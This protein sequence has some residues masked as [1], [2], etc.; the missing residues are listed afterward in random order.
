MFYRVWGF[1]KGVILYEI[2]LKISEVN[3]KVMSNIKVYFGKI[4]FI[5]FN[6]YFLF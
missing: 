5:I 2:N 1:M 6:E 4:L 3:F